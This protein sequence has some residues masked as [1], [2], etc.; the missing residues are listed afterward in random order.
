MGQSVV[1]ISLTVIFIFFN[2]MTIHHLG[3]VWHVFGHQQ[4]VLGGLYHCVKSGCDRCSSFD[5]NILSDWLEN[6]YSRSQ[7]G[8]FKG[9]YLLNKVISTKQNWLYFFY[10]YGVPLVDKSA[11]NLA[12]QFADISPM[13]NFLVFDEGGRFCMGLKFPIS[14]DKTSSH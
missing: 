1:E 2:M 5:L 7:M 6:A 8:V 3:F 11:V 4:G 14:I 13:T 9:F 10:S 12:L